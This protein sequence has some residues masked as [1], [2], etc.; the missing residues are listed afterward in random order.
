LYKHVTT[1]VHT[2]AKSQRH[3][4]LTPLLLFA[5]LHDCLVNIPALRIAVIDTRQI[6]SSL[7]TPG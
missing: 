4:C 3:A 1:G 2:V 6:P 5:T 7:L